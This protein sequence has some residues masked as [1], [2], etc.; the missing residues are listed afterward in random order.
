MNNK[1]FITWLIFVF[2]LIG[3]ER[4]EQTT[5]SKEIITKEKQSSLT[6]DDVVENLKIGN[7][8][9]VSNNLSPIDYLAQA[10]ATAEGQYPEAIILSCID[11]R[12]PV[13]L[14]FDKGIGD[15]FV[16]RVAGNFEDE[17]ILGSMEYATAVAGSKL[18]VVL[19]HSRCG[20]VKGT[21]DKENVEK[22]GLENLNEL[23]EKIEPAV[24]AALLPDEERSPKNHDLIDRVIE[25]NVELAIERIR[26]KSKTLAQLEEEG[27]IKIVGAIYDIET[28]VVR[29]MQ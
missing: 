18:V 13:E 12:V 25:K 5:H 14:I 20:A 1:F 2:L 27:K 6:P 24:K 4:T 28:G 15:I 7:N 16:A 19:G 8:N 11:S 9:F 21:I 10:E 26:E 29:W 23:L 3:C 22:L 17:D